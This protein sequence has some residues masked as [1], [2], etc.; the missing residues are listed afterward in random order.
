VPNTDRDSRNE[1]KKSQTWS[2]R[3]QKRSI[4]QV[5]CYTLFRS[6][7]LYI[8]KEGGVVLII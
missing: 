8:L 4:F 1:T 7:I 6:C 2:P 5:D 3:S